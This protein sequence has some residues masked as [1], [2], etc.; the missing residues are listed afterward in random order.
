MTASEAKS[1]SS[2][3]RFLVVFIRRPGWRKP[4]WSLADQRKWAECRVVTLLQ[5][6]SLFR[7]DNEN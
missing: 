6:L 5:R 7:F 2:I 3:D 4:D 1:H